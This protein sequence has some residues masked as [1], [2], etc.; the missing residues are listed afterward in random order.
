MRYLLMGAVLFLAGCAGAPVSHE[1]VS[2]I[3][4][5]YSTVECDGV[6]TVAYKVGSVTSWGSGF[7]IKHNGRDLLCTAAHVVSEPNGIL[8]LF[9]SDG[10]PVPFTAI[11]V[12]K[13][14]SNDAAFFVIE[15]LPAN[16]KRWEVGAVNT[17][18]KV[19]VIGYPENRRE[20]SKGTVNKI[21]MELSVPVKGG[22]SGGIVIGPDG[23]A[24]GI[25]T[26]QIMM[27]G[28]NTAS[29]CAVLED[30]L[31]TME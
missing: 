20:Q 5:A 17:K 12:T 25:V 19:Q 16:V 30:A 13:N 1:K 15:G 24:A 18:N 9:Y 11:S 8:Q 22:M 31:A 4:T 7:I 27:D 2:E 3:S 26:H 28:K 6:I 21:T 14:L 29:L 10:R 23:K